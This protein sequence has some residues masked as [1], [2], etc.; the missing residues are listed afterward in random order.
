LNRVFQLLGRRCERSWANSADC[1]QREHKACLIGQ[2]P[3]CGMGFR[4]ADLLTSS[5]TGDHPLGRMTSHYLGGGK[6]FSD[7]LVSF[8]AKPLAVL[9]VAVEQVAVG[10]RV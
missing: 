8:R 10:D 1:L 5:I 3:F 9:A 4:Q 7:G 6:Q 2:E